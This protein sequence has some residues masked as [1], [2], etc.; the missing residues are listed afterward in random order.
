MSELEERPALPDGAP[1]ELR[2]IVSYSLLSGLCPL[3]PVPLLDDWARDLLRRR[4][5]A[6]LT[7]SSGSSLADAQIKILATGYDPS[8]PGGCLLGCLV[9]RPLLF[10]SQL[11]FRKLMR[12][13]LFFLTLR[14]T[15]S[16]FS[17][18][19]HEGYL[20][21]HALA[22]GALETIPPA[23][24]PPSNLPQ[25]VD[26]RLL[27]VRQAI[28]TVVR[29]ADTRPVTS[30]VRS[31]FKGSWRSIL[32]TARRMTRVLTKGRRAG[33]QQLSER[34]QQ[35]GEEKL[36]DLIDELTSD[37]A[38]QDSYLKHLEAKLDERLAAL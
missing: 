32:L 18:T 10:L 24:E 13:I 37:L 26:P 28:E 14:D 34:L 6:Q 9:L 15:V 20:V 30:L 21:R 7:A 19:F 2:Q 4:L 29:S 3:I 16:T 1:R 17:D 8:G 36:G 35:E 25:V 27:G 11:I 33:E 12:K 5:V 38:H 22:R 23:T 31:L